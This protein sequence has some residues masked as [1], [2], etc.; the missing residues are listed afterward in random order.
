MYSQQ[1]ETEADLGGTAKEEQCLHLPHMQ[2]P[3]L[4]LL[5]EP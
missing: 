5:E 4:K 3:G 2:S 1:T